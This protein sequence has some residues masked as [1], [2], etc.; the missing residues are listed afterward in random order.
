MLYCLCPWIVP[1][2]CKTNL[3]GILSGKIL[4][5]IRVT[6]SYYLC[7]LRLV[8]NLFLLFSSRSQQFCLQQISEISCY[9][10]GRWWR[11]FLKLW[12]YFEVYFCWAWD[13]L[14]IYFYLRRMGFTIVTTP[15]E[16][17][18]YI[19]I[20]IQKYTLM[21]LDIA[22]EKWCISSLQKIH[23]DK[24]S[25]RPRGKKRKGTEILL[26]YCILLFL[27]IIRLQVR[28]KELCLHDKIYS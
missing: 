3:A 2:K 13:S 9:V 21:V 11:N 10:S 8:P 4:T 26:L 6:L 15:T 12:V 19:K 14:D 5:L 16:I 27:I 23:S 1:N 17:C 25:T 18:F 28:Q 20:F 7:L 22:M 24:I